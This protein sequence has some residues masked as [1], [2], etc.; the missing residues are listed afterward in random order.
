MVP[1]FVGG[2][3]VTGFEFFYWA[4]FVDNAGSRRY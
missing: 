2:P 1:K 3:E 4:K